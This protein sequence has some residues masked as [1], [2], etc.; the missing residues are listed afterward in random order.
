MTH[1]RVARLAAL[2]AG[3]AVYLNPQPVQGSADPKIIVIRHSRAG[4][5]LGFLDFLDSGSRY[6]GL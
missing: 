1:M 6:P 4:G 5:N 3:I 2:C